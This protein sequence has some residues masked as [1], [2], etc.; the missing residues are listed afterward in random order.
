MDMKD[1]ALELWNFLATTGGASKGEAYR[2]LGFIPETGY[3]PLCELAL[4]KARAQNEDDLNCRDCLL[5]NKWHGR[6][7][8]DLET[9][10]NKETYV[11][12]WYD[13]KTKIS[14]QVYAK[15]VHYNL[16]KEWETELDD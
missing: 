15:A 7:N 2:F 3:C 16:L 12:L 14:R 11:R 1:K 9:C 4:A 10:M 13:A 5:Y 6:N 8:T